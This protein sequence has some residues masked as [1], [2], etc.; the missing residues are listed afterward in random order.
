MDKVEKR[1]ACPK[2]ENRENERKRG[3]STEKREMWKKVK[4]F[5]HRQLKKRKIR[6]IIGL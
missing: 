5:I 2:A 6:D 4:K 3:L 1:E